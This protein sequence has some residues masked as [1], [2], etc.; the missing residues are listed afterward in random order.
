MET[1]L[2]I[3][4]ILLITL[5]ILQSAK[6]EGASQIIQGGNLDLFSNRKERGS[7][8]FITR[9]TLV[10]GVLFFVICLFMSLQ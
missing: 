3:I 9:L 4:S 5:V 2:I 1:F 8:L 6:A 7:E 10:L